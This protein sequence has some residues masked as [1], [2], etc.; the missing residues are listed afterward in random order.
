[1][2][3]IKDKKEFIQG[4]GLLV[5]TNMDA[6]KDIM[7]GVRFHTKEEIVYDAATVEGVAPEYRSFSETAGIVAKDG[8][9]RVTLKPTNFND[10]I[11]KETIDADAEQF[12]QNEYGEGAIDPVMQSALTGVGKLKLNADVG[13]KKIFYEA[14]A[15][16]KI[17]NGYI[18]K[19]GREDIVFNVPA[20]NREVF[21]GTAKKYWSNSAS[22]PVTD[23]DRAYKAMKIK[24]SRVIM[25][26]T[27]FS[28][29]MSNGQVRTADNTSTGTKRN[30]IQ[31]ENINPDAK[32]YEA[33]KLIL[34]SGKT[35]SIRVEE[36]Q[37]F[38]G[39]GYVPYMPNGYVAYCS[40]NLGRM[41]YGGIPVAEVGVGVRRIAAMEDV[42]EI[43]TQNP[44]QHFIQYRTAPL[45]AIEQGEGYYSQKVE[46]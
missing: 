41:H 4:I 15:T 20:A 17:A 12:G 26:D 23:I 42:E 45:P 14:L 13:K 30:F 11:S 29:F 19:Q 36:E 35:I 7:P 1:M 16:H 46:A 33:G 43:I 28:N 21:D 34:P 39:T 2:A 27:T 40:P 18:G 8:K 5:E 32:Y 6:I 44:P 38:T 22:T 9:D 10:A 37:R 3:L 24:P 31:N 25:N